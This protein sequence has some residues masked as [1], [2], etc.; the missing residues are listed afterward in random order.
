MTEVQTTLTTC[1]Y[2]GVGCGITASHTSSNLIASNGS[3]DHPANLGALC[4]KGVS[5]PDTVVPDGRLLEPQ[6]DGENVSWNHA[7]DQIAE[8]LMNIVEEHGPESIAFYLSGQ[9]LTEDYYVANKLAKGFLG[10]ANVDTNS[11][12][13]MAS[14]VAAHKR[15]FGEDVVPCDYT[16]LEQCELLVL[17]GSNAAWTHPVLYRRISAAKEKSDLRVV[18]ID[19]R[20]T[21]TCDIADLHLRLDPGSDA[22]LFNGLLC[23][24]ESSGVADQ[25]FIKNHTRDFDECLAV[26]S[27]SV[28]SLSSR[29]GLPE[30]E[31]QKFFDWFKDT[32]RVVTMYSQ[33][34]NQSES[35]TDKCNAIINCHLVTGRIGRPGM[36]PFSITGQPNAMGGREVGGMANQL[37]AHMDFIPK[38]L[39]Q[40]EEFW[41]AKNLA[42]EPG[43]KAVDMFDALERA[44]IR[45]IWIMGTNPAV[46]LPNANRITKA[47]KQC[48]LVIVS[49]CVADT[50]TARLANVLLPA[51]PW[52]EKDGTV[53]NSERQISR[54]RA[55][56]PLSGNARPDWQ[57]ISD[58]AQL[59]GFVT[60]FN[61][62]SPR[63]IFCEHAALTRFAANG[64]RLFDIAELSDL[65]EQ[66]Y[67]QLEPQKWPL[68]SRPFADLK[69]STS[70]GRARF[71]P[72][73]PR[74]PVQSPSRTYPLIL[75]T[76]RLR[77]QWH[78][79]TRTGLAPALFRH[80]PLPE[81]E[82]APADLANKNIAD[83]DL[84]EVANANGHIRGFAKST[85]A[86]SAGQLFTSIHWSGRYAWPTRVSVLTDPVTDPV[87]G[88]PESKQIAVSLRKVSVQQWL[89]L[90]TPLD[91]S[92]DS[93]DCLFYVRRAIDSGYRFDVALPNSHS[94][95]ETKQKILFLVSDQSTALP[96]NQ[97][98]EW[99]E[100]E[101]TGSKSTRTLL[102]SQGQVLAIASTELYRHNL[103]D[104]GNALDTLSSNDQ[105]DISWRALSANSATGNSESSVCTCFEV[106]QQSI[107]SAITA[108]AKTV[109]E[110]GEKL[111]CGTNCGSCIPELRQFLS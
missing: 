110:L 1:P 38:H 25:N 105:T 55:L 87:S 8:R 101:G 31:L 63:E 82:I 14:A 75:N 33:G 80:A 62:H 57:I 66:D 41:Q 99:I 29:T 59:M 49:D 35:G 106:S 109:E 54:Q 60:E 18:V 52:G 73:A 27:S 37:A 81:I 90:A 5:L 64:H 94:L 53:T 61:Y 100:M 70:D 84:V 48:P 97:C 65:S 15:A 22:E 77:D 50:E 16:D 43:L 107:E 3:A 34:V 89:T 98:I 58:V 95:A 72:I 44:D 46:S 85:A 68:H 108:G 9:L 11:R 20:H 74:R 47:L 36:G 86:N 93:I 91:L 83:G 79:M 67:E 92:I 69:F 76:G 26:A 104:V 88:Q 111:K 56:F 39:K 6:I 19:P 51:A 45:A 7:L 13:C 32:E 42:R 17:V 2:C 102:T 28:N 23:H 30:Q 24:L 12:L 96:P 4:V 71:L 21:A 103:L 40:L 78:T 10:C